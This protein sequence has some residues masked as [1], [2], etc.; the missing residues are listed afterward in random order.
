ME[1]VRKSHWE[2]VYQTKDTTKVGWFQ[3]LPQVSTAFI[4][5]VNLPKNASI[6][7]VGAGDGL[8]VDWLLEND[9]GQIT[10]LDISA[11]ALQ[12]AKNRL[13]DPASKVNWEV[14]DIVDFEP[15]RKF[16]FWHDRAVF[17]FLTEPKDQQTYLRLVECSIPSGG[18][19]LVMT[20]SRSGP[21]TCSGLPVQQYDVADLEEFFSQE[22]ELVRSMNYDHFTPSGTAQ[23]YS[24]GLFRR[25]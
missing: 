18:Y 6:I 4:S 21:K 7:D 23:N 12:K 8:L 24:V 5:E 14:A 25:K 20:F 3:P 11:S 13:G 19:L 17:H 1:K 15:K 10:V 22:F 2:T 16:D 9:F